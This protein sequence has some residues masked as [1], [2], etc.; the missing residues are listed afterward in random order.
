[1]IARLLRPLPALFRVGF[2]DAVAYRGEM[3][4]WLL[5]TNTP[6]IML[7][8]W[9]S[10]ASEAPVGRFGQKDFAAYFLVTLV[11]RLLTGAWVAWEIN[12]EIRQGPMQG[13]LLKPLH[14]FV[15]YASENLSAWPLRLLMVLPVVGVIAWVIGP[16]ALSQDWRQWASF[17]VALFGAWAMTF[18]AMLTIGAL[19]FFWHS[20]LSIM[21]VWFGLFVVFSGYIIPLELFPTWFQPVLQWLPFPYII[22][23]PVEMALGL[24][25][26]D[27]SLDRL[28]VQWCFIGVFFTIA[29]VVWRAGVRRYEAFGG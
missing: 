16:E 14:P 22:S 20:T 3:L 13:R 23:L 26:F 19:S 9:T 27:E 1:M 12:T 24:M 29:N 8:L 10:V 2:A 18:C 5:S 7:L 21:E 17:P 4:I 6:L 25:P 28:V 11:V 15:A